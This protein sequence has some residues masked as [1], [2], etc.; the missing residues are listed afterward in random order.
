MSLLCLLQNERCKK[1]DIV[2]QRYSAAVI[3]SIWYD[4]N[5]TMCVKICNKTVKKMKLKTKE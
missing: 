3:K 2:I 4:I 1:S 5:T